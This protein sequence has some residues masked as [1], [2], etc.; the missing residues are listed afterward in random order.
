GGTLLQDIQ[1]QRPEAIA[2]VDAA[3]YDQLRHSVRFA[4]GSRLA[5]MYGSAEG[6]V[7]NSIH[8]QAVDRLGGDLDAEAHSTEDGIVESIRARG[9]AFIVGVQWHPEFHY[10]NQDL[11]RGDPL[12]EGFLAAARAT[13]EAL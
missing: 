2:H 7:V 1:T 9:S 6:G 13:Q 8:H 10:Q 12:M 5:V 4:A 3:L 11:L